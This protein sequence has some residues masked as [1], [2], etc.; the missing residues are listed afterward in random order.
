MDPYIESS[1][2]WG[3]FHGSLLAAIRSEL[4]ARLP[5]GFAAS[6]ELFVWAGDEEIEHATSPNEP[7]VY[8]R[9]ESV[10]RVKS[11]SATIAAPMTIV[12]PRPTPR[13]RKYLKVTDVRAK[14]V[15]TVVEVLSPSNKKHGDDRALYLEKRNEYLASKLS[16]VEIDLL[17]GGKRPPLGKH[18]PEVIDYYALVCRSWDFP[19]A[20]FWSFGI[21]ESIPDIP[22]PVTRETGDTILQ[23]G[24]CV[25]RAYDGGRYRITLP[26]DEPLKPKAREQDGAWIG[27][28]LKKFRNR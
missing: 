27:Q 10:E 8:V 1:G 11:A 19:R 24:Q 9:E 5:D 28:V 13:K 7:D 26:Y 23:L 16:F 22:I 2:L 20:D 17:R 6:I 12:L 18:H 14:R 3:D 4:N 25:S 15:V 21:R